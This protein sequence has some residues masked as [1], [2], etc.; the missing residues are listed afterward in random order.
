MRLPS[1]SKK[2]DFASMRA[3]GKKYHLPCMTVIY[4]QNQD[5]DSSR[6]AFAISGKLANAVSRNKIRRRIREAL[7]LTINE[8]DIKYDILFIPKKNAIDVDYQ[9]LLTQI[10]KLLNFLGNLK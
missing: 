4:L 2:S 9:D 7:R 10:K 8:I 5:L 1:I 6:I 3:H